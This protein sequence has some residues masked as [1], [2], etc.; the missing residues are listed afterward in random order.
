MDLGKTLTICN[1]AIFIIVLFLLLHVFGYL[2]TRVNSSIRESMT[3]KEVESLRGLWIFLGL[4]GFGFF[5]ILPIRAI[6][7]F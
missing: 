5:V 3:K 7:R 2:E 6:F 4:I 1:L